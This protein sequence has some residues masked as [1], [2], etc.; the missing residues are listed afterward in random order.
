MITGIHHV[1]MVVKDLEESVAFY[2]DVLGFEVILQYPEMV[3]DSDAIGLPGEHAKLKWAFLKAGNGIIELHQ[4]LSPVGKPLDRRN[5]DVGL[6]H[7]AF[8]VANIEE[9]YQ[10]LLRKGVKFN[11]KPLR[12]KDGEAKGV[13]WVYMQD[14]DGIT[15]EL[16]QLP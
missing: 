10:T 13:H 11:Y 1:E 14:P 9:V 5:C 15:V 12:I 2:R 3:V 16:Y 4:Y 8:T 7:V 6:G